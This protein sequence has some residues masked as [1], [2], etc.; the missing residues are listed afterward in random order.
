[1]DMLNLTLNAG[2]ETHAAP[3]KSRGSPSPLHDTGS[4]IIDKICDTVSALRCYSRLSGIGEAP[5][6]S[7]SQ[8][9]AHPVFGISTP[10]FFSHVIEQ[11]TNRSWQHPY[12]FRTRSFPLLMTFWNAM[13]SQIPSTPAGLPA[14]PRWLDMPGKS[15][16]GGEKSKVDSLSQERG[17]GLL[18]AQVSQGIFS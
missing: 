5:E 2:R 1:M 11:S 14:Q 4:L 16:T 3:R 12:L 6:L 7:E 18:M 10:L 13:C 17:R 8:P 15:R 9:V